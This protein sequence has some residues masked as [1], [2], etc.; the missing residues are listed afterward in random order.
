[1]FDRVIQ[2]SERILGNAKKCEIRHELRDLKLSDHW[3]VMLDILGL[4]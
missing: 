1:M 2:L 4:F 3:P